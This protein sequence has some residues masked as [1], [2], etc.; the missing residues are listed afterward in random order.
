MG[1]TKEATIQLE[2]ADID[3]VCAVCGGSVGWGQGVECV[4]TWELYRDQAY[5]RIREGGSASKLNKS[6]MYK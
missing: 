2:D 3:S 4:G 5:Y 6:G 1:G